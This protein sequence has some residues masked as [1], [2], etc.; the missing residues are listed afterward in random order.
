MKITELL[1]ADSVELNV[2]VSD[3]EGAIDKLVSLMERGGRLKDRVLYKEEILK[4][5]A[6]GSTAVGEGIAIPHAKTKAVEEAGLAAIVVP[7][8]VDYEAFDGSAA[9]LIFMIAA[10][11]GGADLHLEALSRLSTLLMDGD[12]KE[13][14]I[15]AESKEEFLKLIDDK[16]SERYQ[17]KS[18]IKTSGY[19]VLA[20]TACPTGIAH[21]F[22]AAENLEKSGKQMGISLKAETNGA[23]GIGNALTKEE[24]AQ[25]EGIIIAADKNCLL[26]TSPSP[27]D[28]S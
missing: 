3:K 18:D 4:R 20:V 10:P 21:T 25:A 5:E 9:N 8:G 6:H 2:T 22:M 1:K 17:K 14:L 11:E 19:R 12:F 26:Y 24:I 28:C 7:D 23:E 16:E 15:H 27:R 13:D